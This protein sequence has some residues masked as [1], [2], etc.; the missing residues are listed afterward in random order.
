MDYDAALSLPY[1]VAT[2]GNILLTAS[3]GTG[4]ALVIL[5]GV[6]QISLMI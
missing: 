4:A 3:Y 5:G 1:G 2:M 6:S